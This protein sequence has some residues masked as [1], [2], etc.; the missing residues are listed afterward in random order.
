MLIGARTKD[1]SRRVLV[2]PSRGARRRRARNAVGTAWVAMLAAAVLAAACA[3]STTGSSTAGDG[4][5]GS[6]AALPE[7][8]ADPD[9]SL[10]EL[11]AA[12]K[13]EGELVVY[14]SSGDIKEVAE[15]FTAKYGIQMEG[16]KSETDVTAEKLIR[17]HESGN[18]T[19]DAVLYSDGGVLVSELIPRDVVYTWLPSDLLDGIRQEKRNPLAALAKANLWVYNPKLFPDGCPISNLWELTEP[20]WRGKVVMQDPLGK[21]TTLLLL[22]QLISHGAEDLAAAYQEHYGEPLQTEEKNAAWEWIKRISQNDPV[23]TDSDEDITTAV[24]APQQTE[25]LL[26]Y[27]SIAK[28]RNI[29]LKDFDMAACEGLQPWMG[30]SYD[31][32]AAI[33][34]KTEHPNA[35]KLFVHFIM[36]EEGVEHEIHDGGV[37][38]ND[39][40]GEMNIDEVPGLNDWDGDLFHT[41]AEQLAADFRLRQDVSDFWRLNHG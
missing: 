28:F 21:P 23:L 15:A 3:P 26:G 7:P 25:E 14:D 37:S 10:D 12:A 32:Y 38:G 1:S 36:T 20:E 39:A 35:A 30:F 33:A 2:R 29:E 19:I 27:F 5:R 4:D 11:I 41:Q 9:V 18:V 6:S 34:T 24:N 8:S 13:Q 16:V 31:K 40:V 22:T 17:E